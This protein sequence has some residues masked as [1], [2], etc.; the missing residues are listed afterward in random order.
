MEEVFNHH[1]HFNIWIL[2]VS[3]NTLIVHSTQKG[4]QEQMSNLW[5]CLLWLF[6]SSIKPVQ[7]Q[8]PLNLHLWLPSGFFTYLSQMHHD[9]LQREA[10]LCHWSPSLYTLHHLSMVFWKRNTTVL[11]ACFPS[12]STILSCLSEELH[13]LYACVHAAYHFTFNLSLYL[14]NCQTDWNSSFSYSSNSIELNSLVDDCCE[15]FSWSGSKP[16]LFPYAFAL[17]TSNCSIDW[18]W[19]KMSQSW[20]I[21][22]KSM[23]TLSQQEDIYWRDTRYHQL[24]WGRG[25]ECRFRMGR[26]ELAIYK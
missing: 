20:F 8:I 13:F 25:D 26:E 21:S 15:C 23:R 2:I 14:Q 1:L 3:K 11:L 6:M 22:L 12:S 7:L 5:A 24:T 4:L 18:D 9:Y 17:N 16:A 19:K 10:S